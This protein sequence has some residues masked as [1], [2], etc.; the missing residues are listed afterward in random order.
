MSGYCQ[1]E[2]DRAIFG[3]EMAF[4]RSEHAAKLAH[5][6]AFVQQVGG[7]V[8]VTHRGRQL[9]MLRDRLTG[10]C[11]AALSEYA[12]L[13]TLPAPLQFAVLMML[14]TIC[15]TGSV[16]DT[17]SE[18]DLLAH[19]VSLGLVHAAAVPYMVPVC[20][21]LDAFDIEFNGLR[22]AHPNCRC[23]TLRPSSPRGGTS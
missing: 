23:T 13:H 18:P 8:E 4:V 11:E 15:H 17:R 10:E 2:A 14:E 1:T 7:I 5:P 20:M 9:R 3:A 21:P 22:F 12:A 6:E 16:A 19:L